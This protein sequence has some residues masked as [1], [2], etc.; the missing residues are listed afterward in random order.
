MKSSSA[1]GSSMRDVSMMIKKMP[2]YQKE[3][4]RYGT[5]L[6]LAE[7]V[8]RI[9]QGLTEKLCKVEQVS[10][11]RC[12]SAEYRSMY[13]KKQAGV[14]VD[15]I[16]IKDLLCDRTSPWAATRRARRSRTTCAASCRCCSTRTAAH[17]TRF[18][19]C[20]STSFT[21]EVSG[22]QTHTAAAVRVDF[23]FQTIRRFYVCLFVFGLL[24]AMPRNCP[25]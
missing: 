1:Q 7:D 4:S 25:V 24:S 16:V 21:R 18:A 11:C 8:M 20:S 15:D 17:S 19:A 3:L 12:V 22:T 10:V 6:H 5:Y 2:Q 23:S 13:K 14:S 9:Y